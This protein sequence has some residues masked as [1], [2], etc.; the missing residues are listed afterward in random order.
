M[1]LLDCMKYA[2]AQNYP[3]YYLLTLKQ[4]DLFLSAVRCVIK[5][6]EIMRERYRSKGQTKR[7]QNNCYGIMSV[8]HFNNKKSGV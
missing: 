8:P 5:G 1:I 3:I 2:E 4:R 7:I 6:Y